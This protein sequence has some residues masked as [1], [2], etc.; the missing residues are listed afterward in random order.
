MCNTKTPKYTTHTTK[1]TTPLRLLR[2]LDHWAFMTIVFACGMDITFLFT[3]IFNTPLP[4]LKLCLPE[5][6]GAEFYRLTGQCK[7]LISLGL[8]FVFMY[9]KSKAMLFSR[10]T[11][12]LMRSF[13]NTTLLKSHCS[14]HCGHCSPQYNQYSP[15]CSLYSHCS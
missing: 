9:I 6:L 10:N 4:P 2:L 13:E 8:Y 5:L 7:Y 1:T 3:F 14:P 12:F 11:F 15:H